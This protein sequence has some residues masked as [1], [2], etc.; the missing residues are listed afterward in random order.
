MHT[1]G[2]CHQSRL[3]QEGLSWRD[4]L[5]LQLKLMGGTQQQLAQ[6]QKQSFYGS[7]N[8]GTLGLQSWAHELGSVRV[9]R[10]ARGDVSGPGSMT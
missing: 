7:A 10:F 3:F 1:L 5:K 9:V 2:T 4:F 8:L 6:V